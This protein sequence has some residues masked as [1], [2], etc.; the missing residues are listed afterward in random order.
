MRSPL[1]LLLII[2]PASLSWGQL[3]VQ[4]KY[5]RLIVPNH[6][7]FVVDAPELIVDTLIMDNHSKLRF[8]CPFTTVV[9]RHALIGKKCKWLGRGMPAG[10]YDKEPMDGASLDIEITIRELGQLNIDVS[11]GLGY[12]GQAGM[13]GAPGASG[14]TFSG[15]GRGGDGG[16]GGDGGSGGNI[17]FRYRA[18]GEPVVFTKAKRNSVIINVDGGS[19]GRGGTGGPGGPGGIPTGRSY[20]GSAGKMVYETNG[21]R[22]LPGSRGNQGQTG[23]KGNPG[24]INIVELN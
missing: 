12:T 13:P 21:Q 24:L 17:T 22:G 23:N 16:P 10:N 8:T 9:I 15:G 6:M 18:L 4:G 19:G 5:K 7:E 2:I 14:Q 20:E 3:H 11:G 1:A